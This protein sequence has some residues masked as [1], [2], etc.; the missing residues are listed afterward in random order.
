MSTGA[1]F[2]QHSLMARLDFLKQTKFVSKVHNGS[3]YF[4]SSVAPAFLLNTCR[5]E[6]LSGKLVAISFSTYVPVK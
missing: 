1:A 2:P 6:I 4:A 3:H 5:R